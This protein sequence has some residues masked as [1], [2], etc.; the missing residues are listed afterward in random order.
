[1]SVPIHEASEKEFQARMA[2]LKEETE[3]DSAEVK[4]ALEGH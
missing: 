2:A 4:A 1:M 3:Q